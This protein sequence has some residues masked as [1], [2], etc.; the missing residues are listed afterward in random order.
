MNKER[1]RRL[2]KAGKMT[3]AGLVKIKGCLDEKFAFSND[4]LEEVKQDPVVWNNFR[5]FSPTYK[6]I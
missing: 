5:N 3:T 4:I 6:R 2:I 1:A